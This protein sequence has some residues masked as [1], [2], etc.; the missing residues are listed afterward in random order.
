MSTLLSA[1]GGQ[2][3]ASGAWRSAS[4]AFGWLF[5]CVLIVGFYVLVFKAIRGGARLGR[6][7]SRNVAAAKVGTLSQEV[8]LPFGRPGTP[9]YV[10]VHR[11]GACP[12]H[13]PRHG[14]DG[15]CTFCSWLHANGGKGPWGDGKALLLSP[16]DFEA[17]QA[18]LSQA[19]GL[20]YLDGTAAGWGVPRVLPG[21]L[22]LGGKAWDQEEAW[23]R[24]LAERGGTVHWPTQDAYGRPWPTI[25]GTAA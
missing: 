13:A 21:S 1:Q 17:Y 16:N 3:L 11:P 4:T 6:R 10:P 5:W 20:P 18:R 19:T 7:A 23:L 8:T 15:L 24:A 9:L 25:E 14:A 2:I 22:A 12:E